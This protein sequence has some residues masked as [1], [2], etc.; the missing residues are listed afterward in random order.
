MGWLPAQDALAPPGELIHVLIPFIHPFL[1]LHIGQIVPE[2]TSYLRGEINS[3]SP[4]DSKT[5]F[6]GE[7]S[8]YPSKKRSFPCA[9]SSQHQGTSIEK[10]L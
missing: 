9:R 2:P 1:Q 5:H 10:T 7:F 3:S 4:G 8:I 6:G